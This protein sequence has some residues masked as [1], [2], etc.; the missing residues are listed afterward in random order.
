MD[1]GKEQTQACLEY[2]QEEL[3]VNETVSSLSVRAQRKGGRTGGWNI[4]H[5]YKIQT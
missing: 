3:S 5:V 2:S 4:G 1:R